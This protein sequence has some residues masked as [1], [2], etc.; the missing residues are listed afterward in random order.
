MLLVKKK[1]VTNKNLKRIIVALKNEN[2]LKKFRDVSTGATGATV[3]APKF[4][5][6]LTLSQSRGADSAHHRRGRS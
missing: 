2:E 4:S 3:V 6:T 5:D 1:I